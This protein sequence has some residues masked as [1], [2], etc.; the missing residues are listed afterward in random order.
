MAES[1]LRITLR[2][3]CLSVYLSTYLHIFVYFYFTLFMVMGIVLG[4]LHLYNTPYQWDTSTVPSYFNI[5]AIGI[6]WRKL[7]ETWSPSRRKLV[8]AIVQKSLT[9]WPYNLHG[10]CSSHLWDLL[11]DHS[12]P[13]KSLLSL[14][15]IL[16]LLNAERALNINCTP[17]FIIA[18]WSTGV[19]RTLNDFN[20]R[21]SAQPHPALNISCLTNTRHVSIHPSSFNY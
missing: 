20:Y 8:F 16:M 5:L 3:V 6:N 21:V 7:N 4:V 18:A 2:S 19:K 12:F 9:I 11:T 1:L 15:V 10:K 13:L 17:Q 14:K